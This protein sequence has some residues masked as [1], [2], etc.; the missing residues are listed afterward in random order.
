MPAI[1]L[2]CRV[3][4][5]ELGLDAVGACEKCLGPL[6]PVYDL[7]SSARG[8]TRESIAAGPLSIWRYGALLPVEPPAEPRLAPG[9]HAA[10]PG[11]AARRGARPGR[12]LPQARHGEPDA[13]VQGPR[14]RG[15]VREGAGARARGR[16][17]ARRPGISPTRSQ[18]G[19]PPRGSKR[20]CSARPTSSPRSSL[21]DRGVRGDDL[22][23]RG[24]Y[25]DCTRLTVELSFELPWAFV[26][27]GLRAYYAEGSKTLAFEIAEQLGWRL[28]TPSSARSPRARSSRRSAQGFGEFRELGLVEARRRG[29][30]GG[31]A[32]GCAPVATAFREERPVTRS[33]RRRSRA[34][35]RSAIPPTATSRWPPRAL[36]RR[37]LRRA[38]GRD[39][40]EHGA[41]RRDKRASSAR[42]PPASALGALREALRQGTVRRTTAS[43]CSSRATA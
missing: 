8:L 23:G 31:Q 17:R 37:D 9:L 6:E 30:I 43:S 22:R 24:S 19:P 5:R 13:L 39:R 32:E 10:R 15:R 28:P 1:S 7:E 35:S 42:R 41:A 33:V 40:R 36:R 34:R 14:R 29:S 18:R 26:N 12:A 16:S 4:G 20:R 3:C 11:A 21:A 38:R 2:R 27:V 25:D